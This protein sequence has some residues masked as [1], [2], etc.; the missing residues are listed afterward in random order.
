MIRAV[1]IAGNHGGIL[2]EDKVES[3]EVWVHGLELQPNERHAE[4]TPNEPVNEC[5]EQRIQ[6]LAS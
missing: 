3:F 5:S 1:K 4:I 2:D 6:Q